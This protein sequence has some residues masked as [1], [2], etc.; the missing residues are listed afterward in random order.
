MIK[1][2]V[3]LDY[4]NLSKNSS[5]LHWL[6]WPV[7]G[8]N[9]LPWPKS[10]WVLRKSLESM[11]RIWSIPYENTTGKQTSRVLKLKYVTSVKCLSTIMAFFEFRKNSCFCNTFVYYKFNSARLFIRVPGAV[12]II[13][14]Y[15]LIFFLFCI[16]IELEI[17][18]TETYLKFFLYIYHAC[19]VSI[20]IINT[21]IL[22]LFVRTKLNNV[23][24]VCRV[25]TVS[26]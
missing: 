14:F 12:S 21:H 3:F 23:N 6:I 1:R 8:R 7:L 19:L 16:N 24:N 2:T 4:R 10:H 9:T 11:R 18:S 13:N 26:I 17:H 25:W 20:C 5:S 22:F 15:K